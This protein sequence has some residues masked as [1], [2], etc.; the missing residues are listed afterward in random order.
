MK[1][2]F[3]FREFKFHILLLSALVFAIPLTGQPYY[4]ISWKTDGILGGIGVVT[5]GSALIMQSGV[6]GLTT[7]EIATLNRADINAFDRGATYNYSAGAQAGGD[8]LMFAS[9]IMPVLPLVDKN[10]KAD[11]GKILLMYA[12]ALLL[13]NG[14]TQLT[15]AI[16]LRTRPYVYNENVP[17]DEKTLTKARYSFYSGHVSTVSSLSFATASILNQYYRKRKFMPFVWSAAVLLPAAT[18]Y[19]RVRAGKHFPTDVIFGYA[20]GAII[21]VLVPNLHLMKKLNE[22]GAT[23]QMGANYLVLNMKF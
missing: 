19:L 6:Q 20:T 3:P 11:Q 15:K 16:T 17:M 10:M 23:I 2:I 13:N 4:D 7:E 14:I 5:S 18:G 9:F 22:R 12:E 1:F 21:G 8:A